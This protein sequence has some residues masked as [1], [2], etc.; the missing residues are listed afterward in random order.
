MLSI[1]FNDSA[2]RKTQAENFLNDVTR[3]SFGRQGAGYLRHSVFLIKLIEYLPVDLS[4]TDVFLHFGNFAPGK[5]TTLTNDETEGI[6]SLSFSSSEARRSKL[7]YK[8]FLAGSGLSLGHR[9]GKL[10]FVKRAS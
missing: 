2:V 1:K 10:F 5:E 9:L 6:F 3:L 7:R 8:V 4:N